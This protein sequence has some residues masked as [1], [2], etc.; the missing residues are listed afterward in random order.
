MYCNLDHLD[1]YM[2]S[3]EDMPCSAV[4]D[5]AVMTNFTVYRWSVRMEQCSRSLSSVAQLS[6][7]QPGPWC[8]TTKRPAGKRHRSF[9]LAQ[10]AS[11]HY[12]H[13]GDDHVRIEFVRGAAPVSTPAEFA[14]QVQTQ[15]SQLVGCQASC[16]T[17]ELKTVSGQQ[18]FSA[19][20][21]LQEGKFRPLFL[22]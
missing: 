7:A 21:T 8:G 14:T 10:A 19:K 12:T 6:T 4:G 11:I 9:L 20:L 17:V 5:L 2:C 3:Y 1:A 13:T 18:Y 15:C 22:D 16:G